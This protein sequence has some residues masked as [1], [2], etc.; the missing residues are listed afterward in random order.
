M[1]LHWSSLQGAAPF[2]RLTRLAARL[3]DV[4]MSMVSMEREGELR[5]LSWVGIPEPW[6]SR[7]EIPHPYRFCAHVFEQGQVEAVGDTAGHP[8]LEPGSAGDVL[9]VGAYLGI[10]LR[11]AE[12]RV[13]GVFSVMD[14][15]PR[16]W[17]PEQ[18]EAFRDLADAA[19][20][21][22]ELRARTEELERAQA[23]QRESELRFRQLVGNIQEAFWIAE[24]DPFRILYVSPALESQY[25]RDLAAI[26]ENFNEWLRDIHPEDLPRVE[27][28]LQS[29][30]LH[31]I[32]IEFR[33]IRPD[34]EIRCLRSRGYP[35]TNE[36]GE[37]YR[38][39]GLTQ[40]ITERRRDERRLREQ[41]EKLREILE[42]ITD[43]FFAIDQEWRIVFA[44]AGAA[45]GMERQVGLQRSQL[46]GRQVWEVLPHLLGTPFEHELRSAMETR[47]PAHFEEYL[48][49][50][51]SWYE[52]HAY[53]CRDG[54]ISVYYRDVTDRRA[55]EE[56]LRA[57]EQRFRA[58]TENSLDT[59]AVLAEDGIIR[60]KSA[61][62]QRELGWSP[63]EMEGHSILEFVHPDD[64]PEVAAALERAVASTESAPG[65]VELRLRHRD[66]SYR[67]LETLIR[68]HLGEPAVAGIVANSRDV[69]ERR[70]A[71]LELRASEQRFR[72]LSES[73]PVGI[74]LTDAEGRADYFNRRWAEITGLAPEEGVGDGWIRAIHPDDRERVVSAW[75]SHGRSQN[76][77]DDSFRILRPDGEVRWVEGRA[78]GLPTEEGKPHGHVGTV[79]DITER[80]RA[81]EQLRESERRFRE[82]ADSIQEVFWM[83]TPDFSETLYVS[84][85][86]ERSF[87][88]SVESLYQAPSSF[89]D[90]VHPDDRGTVR[91]AIERV[92]NEEINVEFR[93][94]Q[95]DGRTRWLRAQGRP[96]RNAMG[97][98]YRVAGI[99]EDVTDYHDA[100]EALGESDRRF[101]LMVENVRDYAI[102]LLDP[103]GRVVEWN[104]GAERVKGYS[105]AQI[106][107]QHI[108]VF[109]PEEDRARGKP[110]RILES[111]R[112]EGH[113][114]DEDWRVRRDGS[115]FWASVVVTALRD[116]AGNLVGF[117]KITR[118][119]SEAH[120]REATLR[121]QS[122]MVELLQHT[123]VAANQ[124]TSVEEALED[125]LE[126]VCKQT[127]F[128]TGGAY[129]RAPDDPDTLIPTGL[130]PRSRL[131]LDAF[132]VTEVRR[133]A[134]GEGLPGRV[135]ATGEPEWI[136]D[137]ALHSGFLRQEAAR[138]AGV[139][140]GISFPVL[141]GETVVAVLEFFAT[142]EISP[143]P[144]LLDTMANIGTQL[145]RVFERKQAEMQVL[146]AKEEAERASRAKSEFLSRM[147]H[148]LRT[149]MNAILGFAQILEMDLQREEDQESV[150]QILRAGRHLLSLIDEVLDLAKIE[151]ERMTLSLEP[152]P[153]ADVVRQCVD[154]VGTMAR[155]RGIAL[156]VDDSRDLH[157]WADQQRL[158]QV[159]L[160]LLS[161][162][163]KYNHEG[164][165][166][167]VTCEDAAG[168][169][170]R[171][172][173]RDT[174]P[175]I[176]PEKLQRLFTPFDRLDADRAQV[177]G[178]GL[179][180]ALSRGLARA[181]GGEIQVESAP[182]EGSTF[183]VQLPR[184]PSPIEGPDAPREDATASGALAEPPASVVLYIEDNLSNLRLVERVLAR[185]PGLTLI[186]AL[187]GRLGL[188]LAR[189]HRPDLILLDV[190][191]PDLPGDQV[192]AELRADPVLRQIPVIVISADAMPRRVEAILAAGA[193]DYLS[194][195]F[196]VSRLMAA[197]DEALTAPPN[198]A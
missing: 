63:Q 60:Y 166:I 65:V 61:S 31:E 55:L 53:P 186:P 118:D 195:P 144:V 3:L 131:G 59:I 159:I 11:T 140:A 82:M 150:E 101:R 34:G 48:A 90:A 37:I 67:I 152:V 180:L 153:V 57:S 75:M 165:S 125:V 126:Y 26:Y 110:E 88:R 13:V 45:A 89:V 145:G 33:I 178:T 95:P 109:Y 56:R 96:V 149:P 177:D 99:S 185:R 20:T 176:A 92:R 15:R 137:V 86:Y 5:A 174:G 76:E 1:S 115:L 14:T 135:F 64:R 169:R 188:D 179:G 142:E 49:G 18:V 171:I 128:V 134:R 50:L 69:T 183:W 78:A 58:L 129:V 160:N 72:A 130:R 100:L 68:S 158:K 54:G 117:A 127:G 111:A 91:A 19:V 27:A 107:G 30:P 39:A 148:E 103:E 93:V 113:Y 36:R 9:G 8:R 182:G 22:V 84:P 105:E 108:S 35:V 42:S 12:G 151:A 71:E 198:R 46:I 157:V 170:L 102:V 124:A 123:A 146:R 106:L 132:G 21:E 104:P 43:R 154:L 164:G 7:G 121:H 163:I 133:V 112:R 141:V 51:R 80:R 192:L 155:Q 161:N 162:A 87:A 74:F 114:E 97:E 79:E 196:D 17:S 10:P 24:P 32:D 2:D 29:G 187:Q 73:A 94:V 189:E 139:H 38:V 98:V 41:E 66:G 193:S 120:A 190:H 23:E 167:T 62:V 77:Y 28:A 16:Q 4:P 25:G 181:M 175:G 81:E 52:V 40:D 85:A 83:F 172:G 6:A 191:L 122:E 47:S 173:I 44:N 147:S 197:V 138:E 184:A 156:H 119:L 70:Q 116:E 194:K 143:D 168:G 136:A